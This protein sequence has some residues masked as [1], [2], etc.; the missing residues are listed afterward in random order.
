MASRPLSSSTPAG[1]EAF[2]INDAKAAAPHR[3]FARLWLQCDYDAA[4]GVSARKAAAAG[5][6]AG[7]IQSDGE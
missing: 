1:Q 6:L 7:Q 2:A 5:S 3:R 4:V